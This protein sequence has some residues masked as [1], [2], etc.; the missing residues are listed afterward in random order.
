[1]I[2][3]RYALPLLLVAAL[4]AG[5]GCGDSGDPE[6]PTTGASTTGTEGLSPTVTMT[7][8]ADAASG[9]EPSAKLTATFSAKMN[10]ATITDVTFT[11]TQGGAAVAGKVEY[12][13]GTATFTPTAPLASGTDFKATITTG[14]KDTAGTALAK[15]HS[16]SFQ[17]GQAPIDLATASTYAILASDAVGSTATPGTVVTGDIGIVPG[18]S[19][20]ATGFPPG[21][22]T[23][24]THVGD[25]A[26]AL[27]KTA[28][29]AAYKDAAARIGAKDLP[30]DISDMTFTP[31]LYKATTPVT[32]EKGSVTLDAK[33]AEN[34]IFIFRTEADFT[35][36]NDTKIVLAGGA[37]SSNVYW[38]VGTA[39]TLGSSSKFIG[40]L[41]AATTVSLKT[42][43]TVDGRL[44]AQGATVAL[45]ANLVTVP[46][47]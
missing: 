30:K 5:F 39:A 21:V 13:E 28:M 3:L 18:M 23:G 45:D 47:P 33:G 15:D 41:L 29:I 40:T 6:F 4:G 35:T 27:A 7:S 32:F 43:A 34:A 8:P 37:K 44:L 46:A 1:M 14:A 22:H 10:F 12:A 25:S 16:W 42:G 2:K 36:G 19:V 38:T 31:G 24:A 9:V 26:G 17:T 20:G 11:L